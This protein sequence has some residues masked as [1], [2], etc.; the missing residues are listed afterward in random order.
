MVVIHEPYWSKRAFG[1][2]EDKLIGEVIEV[3]CD[4]K[5]SDGSL[6]FPDTYQMRCDK[7][8]FFPAQMRRGVK[9]H[10]VPINAFE[11]LQWT[12]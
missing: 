12:H 9:L 3:Q 4:Y 10:I 1:I 5:K 2:A 7:V 8:R 11:V 6:M